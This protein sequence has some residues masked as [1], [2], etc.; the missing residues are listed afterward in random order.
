[1]PRKNKQ[2]LGQLLIQE[3]LISANQ[4]NQALMEQKSTRELLGVTLLR[5][6]F[7]KDVVDVLS[8]L[9]LQMDVPLIHLKDIKIDNDVIN[10][11]P[12]KLANYYKVIPI[13]ADNDLLSVAMS[14]P[15]DI[16]TIDEI[17][18][19]ASV[20][21]KPMLASGD[22]IEEAIRKYYGLGADTIE[23][24]MNTAGIERQSV[25]R[26]DHLDEIGSE[27]SISKF[28]NQM[29]LEAYQDR[30][31]DIHIEPAEDELKIRYRID[32]ILYDAK[33][34]QDIKYFQDALI[35]R[36]KIMSNLNIA[37]KRLPQDGRFKV[38]VAA[39]DLD[40]RISFLPTPWGQSGVI[41]ILNSLRL[42]SLE[43]L[44]LT[45]HEIKI[46]D[47]LIRKPYGI[48]F[49][50]GPTGSGKTTTLYSCLSRVNHEDKKII[51]IED[52]IEYQLKGITQIQVNHEIKLTFAAGLR[53]MLR[54]DPDIMMVGEVRDLETAQIAV[55]SALT[56]HLVLSTLHTNDAASGVTR[57][58]DMDIEPYLI[59]SAVECFVAQR[60]VRV[61]CNQCKTP[62]TI[63]AEMARDF[64]L[65]PEDIKEAHIFEAAGCEVCRMKGYIGRQAICEILLLNDDIRQ[66]VLRRAPS[67]EIKEKAAQLGMK[68]LRQHGWEKIKLGITTPSE[69]MRVTREDSGQ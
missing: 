30:A 48:I 15:Q 35:S 67:G 69:V 20:K 14:N 41:R 2:T 47:Q 11:I 16:H 45:G 13:S 8:I 29:L 59:S 5:L 43:E 49:V 10:R 53:S 32:G 57:L 46:L 56:G 54:H 65:K 50:T 19:M 42:L 64:N 28:L 52:P 7:V 26:F 63:S 27:A 40:L 55:Q 21:I 34:P 60:L 33:V 4:L 1:M 23:K 17:E 66:M 12:A 36:I 9:A 24:M 62:T 37:E 58:I 6:G 3:G 44:G 18:A 38:R 61:L 68:T 51:T 39:E 25:E 22:E 31:T